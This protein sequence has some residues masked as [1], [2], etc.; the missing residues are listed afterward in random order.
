MLH[1]Q[2]SSELAAISN[3]A[4]SGSMYSVSSRPGFDTVAEQFRTHTTE[5]VGTWTRLLHLTCLLQ[6]D[7]MVNVAI[8]SHE[9]TL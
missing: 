1:L 2:T 4:D 9:F 3:A 7:H 6:V 5:V 8:G